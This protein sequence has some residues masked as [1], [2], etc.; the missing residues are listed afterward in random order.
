MVDTYEIPAVGGPGGLL[1]RRDHQSMQLSLFEPVYERQFDSD[2]E[3][4]FARYLDEQK[5]LQWWH[6]VAVRQRG[7][8]Y[9]RGW[10]QDRIWPDFVAMGG[11]NEGKPHVLVF[12]TKGEHLQGN[13]DTDY[14]RR[15]LDTL[16]NA[17]NYGT[18]TVRNGPVK[19]TFRLVFNESEFP[20]TIANLG[21][22]YSA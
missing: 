3:R 6:R 16:Q 14:K 12:E 13:P 18:M 1:A 15:V 8:Y 5:A 19:G 20:T 2:L 10:K 7:E 11:E 22:T 17:F 21:H 4:N 9:L